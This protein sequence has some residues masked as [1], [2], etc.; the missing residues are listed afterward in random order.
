MIAIWQTGVSQQ[1]FLNSSTIFLAPI[2]YLKLHKLYG[3]TISYAIRILWKISKSPCFTLSCNMYCCVFWVWR[4]LICILNMF[5]WYTATFMIIIVVNTS[6]YYLLHGINSGAN[7]VDPNQPA[8]PCRLIRIY[9]VR[10]WIQY[11]LHPNEKE[12][13]VRIYTVHYSLHPPP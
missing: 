3:W 1:H 4:F 6:I 9:T 13:Q 11:T 12:R 10:F 2:S 7:R 5:T 8:N